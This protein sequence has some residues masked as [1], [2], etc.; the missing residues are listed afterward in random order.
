ML[1]SMIGSQVASNASPEP[2]SNVATPQKDLSAMAKLLK[3]LDSISQK[4]KLQ[5]NMMSQKL[6]FGSVEN[7]NLDANA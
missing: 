1:N 6:S 2:R 4:S 7:P 3:P 5:Q